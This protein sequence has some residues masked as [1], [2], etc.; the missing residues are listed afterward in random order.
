MKHNV[1]RAIQYQFEDD[2]FA[3]GWVVDYVAGRAEGDHFVAGFNTDDGPAGE[4]TFSVWSTPGSV[5][6]TFRFV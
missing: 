2:K 5:R 3:Y 6:G 1:G 4:P